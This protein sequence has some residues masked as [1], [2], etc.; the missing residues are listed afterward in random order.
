MKVITVYSKTR[1]DC[2]NVLNDTKFSRGSVMLS[3]N[4]NYFKCCIKVLNIK[5]EYL[6]FKTF[7]TAKSGRI[8]SC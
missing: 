2:D 5:G 1:N 3:I 6:R 7:G 4:I 8:Q